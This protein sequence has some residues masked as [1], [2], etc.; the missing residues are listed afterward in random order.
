MSANTIAAKDPALMGDPRWQFF[1]KA[2]DYSHGADIVPKYPNWTTEIDQR[3][4]AIFK[5]EKPAKAALDEA[6]QVI[7]AQIGQ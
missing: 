6:Q 5:G 2:M 1:L 4:E 7:D 3:R